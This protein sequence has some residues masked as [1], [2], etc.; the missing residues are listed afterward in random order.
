MTIQLRK[1]P[2]ETPEL[3]FPPW[4]EEQ[5][6]IYVDG[7]KVGQVVW[8]FNRRSRAAVIEEIGVRQA[9]RRRGFG[10]YAIDAI[11]RM[12]KKKGAKRLRLAAGPFSEEFWAKLG[13]RESGSL[14]DLPQFVKPLRRPEVHV[15]RHVR[16]RR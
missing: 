13:F 10:R 2:V 9:Y 16:R 7:E 11:A 4:E 8:A 1:V 5:F 6:D 15:R 12:A 3:D 14:D